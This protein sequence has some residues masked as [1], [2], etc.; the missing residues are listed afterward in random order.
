MI[1]KPLTT[2]IRHN[3]NAAIIDLVGDINGTAD[4]A[5]NSAFREALNSDPDSV[6]LNFT[7]VEY[8]NS[9]GIALIVGLLAMARQKK[10]D[11]LTFGLSSHYR[12]IFDITR[13]SDFMKI[14]DDEVAATKQ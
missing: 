9:T 14:V 10:V 7:D 3:E 1:S 6:V 2:Q 13:L 8:I 11:V 5:I 4:T 12:E